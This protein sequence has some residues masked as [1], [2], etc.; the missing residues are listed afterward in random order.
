MQLVYNSWALGGESELQEV[1][2]ETNTGHTDVIQQETDVLSWRRV[3]TT[4][5]DRA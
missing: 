2:G 3:C 5:T 4:V 1:I